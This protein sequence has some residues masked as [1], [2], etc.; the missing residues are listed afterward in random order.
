[1]III[2]LLLI[3]FCYAPPKFQS[4]ADCDNA[5]QTMSERELVEYAKSRFDQKLSMLNHLRDPVAVEAIRLARKINETFF[6]LTC[7][8]LKNTQPLRNFFENNMQFV[9]R[10]IA[11]TRKFAKVCRVLMETKQTPATAAVYIVNLVFV[12]APKIHSSHNTSGKILKNVTAEELVALKTRE[13]VI[14]MMLS[15]NMP[16][17]AVAAHINIKAWLQQLFI[18]I[19]LSPEFFQTVSPILKAFMDSDKNPET[20]IELF[21]R[22]NTNTTLTNQERECNI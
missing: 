22:A 14:R 4:K 21:K 8:N 10:L 3:C 19:H 18:S 7:A 2:F 12:H 16:D 5:L 20:L 1:M 6:P 17:M 15:S 11:D 13:N 9:E